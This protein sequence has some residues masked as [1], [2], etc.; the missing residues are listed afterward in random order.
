MQNLV[1]S[2]MPGRVLDGIALLILPPKYPIGGI[3]GIKSVY[4]VCE[5]R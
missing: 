1:L 2:N 5:E 4:H 3:G